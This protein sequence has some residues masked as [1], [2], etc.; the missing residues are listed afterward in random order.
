[1]PRPKIVRISRDDVK[2]YI[3]GLPHILGLQ[4]LGM[5]RKG[6]RRFEIYEEKNGDKEYIVIRALRRRKKQQEEREE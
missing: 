1:M 2:D 3:C 5:V 4:I 6:Y